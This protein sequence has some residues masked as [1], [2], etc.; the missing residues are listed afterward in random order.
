MQPQ[1]EQRAWRFGYLDTLN[2]GISGIDDNGATTGL[3]KPLA[4]NSNLGSATSSY[5]VEDLD[6]EMGTNTRI[7][8]QETDGTLT[9]NL[10]EFERAISLR[11]LRLT[12][13]IF[14]TIQVQGNATITEGAGNRGA[15]GVY[16]YEIPNAGR[17]RSAL[18]Q[19]TLSGARTLTFGQPHGLETGDLIRS[20]GGTTSMTAGTLNT[21]HQVTKTSD[22]AVDLSAAAPTITT[23]NSI[24]QDGVWVVEGTRDNIGGFRATA[25]T[26]GYASNTIYR[27]I[28]RVKPNEAIELD[29]IHAICLAGQDCSIV[30]ASDVAGTGEVEIARAVNGKAIFHRRSTLVT[31][32]TSGGAAGTYI[33]L[34]VTSTGTPNVSAAT[35]TGRILSTSEVAWKSHL[36]APAP[37]AG[38]DYATLRQV[39]Q[40]ERFVIENI[41][42]DAGYTDEIWVGVAEDAAGTNFVP[43]AGAR[44][45]DGPISLKNRAQIY[46][47]TQDLFIVATA[48][49]AGAGPT[50]GV[51]T[52]DGQVI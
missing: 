28:Y 19:P 37:N 42:L 18:P 34:K 4:I 27:S 49:D 14:N 50:V 25:E 9:T 16:G 30:I 38:K 29:L 15:L 24:V 33:L 6:V 12:T 11:D 23:F 1:P 21:I 41:T 46:D 32:S 51:A 47:T 35:I 22:T 26:I 10:L 31:G 36:A 43:I 3:P 45:A 39:V 7:F 48:Y 44:V 8:L 40:G 20:V 2:G 13:Q 5:S 17:F 52:I